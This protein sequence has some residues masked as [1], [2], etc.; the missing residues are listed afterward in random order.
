MQHTC[1][2]LGLHK[3]SRR[4]VPRSDSPR[5][6]AA[7]TTVLVEGRGL[8]AGAC[9]TQVRCW[10][11]HSDALNAQAQ[12]MLP[13][14]QVHSKRGRRM[15]HTSVLLG[16]AID[17]TCTVQPASTEICSTLQGGSSEQSLR[18]VGRSGAVSSC[19]GTYPHSSGL[20]NSCCAARSAQ[21]RCQQSDTQH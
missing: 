18:I 2:K 1:Y 4:C 17:N 15:Q 13:A 16:M 11:A 7:G 12:F 19:W 6:E 9:N 10:E 21:L 14:L 8:P 5:P 3:V 20:Q